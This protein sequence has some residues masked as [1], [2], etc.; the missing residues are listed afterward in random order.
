V[1]SFPC[2]S[3]TYQDAVGLYHGGAAPKRRTPA[4]AM[5]AVTSVSERT[6]LIYGG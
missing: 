1:A 2:S 5:N 4:L 6:L 3:D